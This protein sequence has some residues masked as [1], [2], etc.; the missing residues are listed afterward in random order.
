MAK[1]GGEVVVGLR[2]PADLV[3]VADSLIPK[4]AKSE[5]G[6]AGRSSRSMV[7]RLAVIRGLEALRS[8][9]K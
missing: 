4:L 9:Y 1:G 6:L 8:E 3:K 2:L 5:F 7:L